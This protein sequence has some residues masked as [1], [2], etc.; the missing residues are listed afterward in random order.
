LASIRNEL[1]VGC[2]MLA[3]GVVTAYLALQMGALG[4]LGR[5]TVPVDVVLADAAGLK[6]DAPISVAGVQVGTVES[7]SVAG[8][9]ARA[10]LALDSE[11]EVYRDATLRVRAASLLGEKYLELVPGTPEAGRV[12]AGDTLADVPEQIEIDELVGAL[13]PV[14]AAVD[15]EDLGR[16]IAALAAALEEDPERLGRMLAN[17][18]IALGN[19]ATASAELP[20]AVSELRG[21]LAAGR[22]TLG[23]VDARVD[24]A[25]PVLARVDHVIADVEASDPGALVAEVRSAVGES[26]QVIATLD[27]SGKNLSVLLDNLSEI[28]RAEL[29]RMLREEGVLIRLFPKKQKK[30]RE[31]R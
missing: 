21:T 10:G 25:G 31:E 24:Q 6:V 23:G 13:G 16:A 9:R 2:L 19:A 30:N 18:D 8:G 26:R 12:V 4:S 20:G 14:L 15:P 22:R 11:A 17:A 29:E 5:S 1:G 28:D 7:L 27:T 3:A